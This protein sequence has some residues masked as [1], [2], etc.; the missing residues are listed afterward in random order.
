MALVLRAALA[1]APAAEMEV[2]ITVTEV[3]LRAVYQYPKKQEK[4]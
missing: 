3:L 1:K 4:Q 2:V